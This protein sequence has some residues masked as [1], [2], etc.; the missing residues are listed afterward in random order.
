MEH[1]TEILNEL[2]DKLETICVN[3]PVSI[4]KFEVSLFEMRAQLNKNGVV[5]DLEHLYDLAVG[6]A[7]ENFEFFCKRPESLRRQPELRRAEKEVTTALC[8]ILLRLSCEG[9]FGET[10]VFSLDDLEEDL[11]F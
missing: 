9:S 6:M 3:G 1:Y 10:D 5:P 11:P 7:K 2:T 4:F 8:Q